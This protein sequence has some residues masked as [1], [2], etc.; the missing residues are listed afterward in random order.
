MINVKKQVFINQKENIEILEDVNL[1]DGLIGAGK[2]FGGIYSSGFV[3]GSPS[4]QDFVTKINISTHEVTSFSDTF[5]SSDSFYG[6]VKAPNGFI[7][8]IPKQSDSVI[9]YNPFNDLFTTFGSDILSGSSLYFSGVL[10]QNNKIYTIPRNA[11]RVLEIN[12]ADDSYRF[13]GDLVGSEHCGGV[14]APNGKIYAPPFR[15]TSKVLI[16]NPITQSIGSINITEGLSGNP[17]YFG[18][19]LGYDGKIYFIPRSAPEVLVVDP[20]DDS[21]YFLSGLNNTT[22]AAWG[23][24]VTAPNGNIYGIPFNSHQ[25]LKIDVEK[26][27]TELIGDLSS[28]GSAKFVGGV[29]APNDKI[30]C[31]PFDSSKVATIDNIGFTTSEM[32]DFPTN[33][34]DLPTSLYNI[35]QNKL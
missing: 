27:T 14:L 8:F 12:V 29:L 7:Y 23:G 19:S 13:I 21:Y 30:Y 22:S 9:K 2:A 25:F 34:E 28:L 4:N 3:I 35:H 32:F 26:Q 1:F 18:G 33:F 16:I 24:A 31:I 17:L 11:E 10:A 5:F 20:T 6:A 15:S